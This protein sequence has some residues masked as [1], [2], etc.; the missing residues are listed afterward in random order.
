MDPFRWPRPLAPARIA[1]YDRQ[2]ELTQLPPILA[3]QS[4]MDFTVIRPQSSALYAHLLDVNRIA[5]FWSF[6]RISAD[7][8]LASRSETRQNS[9]SGI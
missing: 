4:L 5:K 1:R 2:R 3:F 8:S 6:Q 9:R 7:T